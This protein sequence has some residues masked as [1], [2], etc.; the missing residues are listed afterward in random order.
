MTGMNVIG[1][2]EIER[3]KTAVD[4]RDDTDNLTHDSANNNSRAAAYFKNRNIA[5]DI[6]MEK[7]CS[8]T[9]ES[10]MLIELELLEEDA[11]NGR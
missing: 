9:D 3:R 5:Y 2:T 4:I 10:E 7:L 1:K 11:I 6:A 8:A